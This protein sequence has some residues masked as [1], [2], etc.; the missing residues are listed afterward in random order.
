MLQSMNAFLGKWMPLLTP[1]SV[2]VGVLLSS[3]LNNFSFL[4]PWVFAAMTFTGSLNSNFKSMKHTIFHPLSLL[5]TLAVLHVIT[6]VWAYAIGHLFFGNDPYTIT[7]LTLATVI[8]TGITSVIWVSMYKGNVPLTLA[9]ILADTLLSPFLVPLSMSIFVGEAVQLDVWGMMRGL[10][11]MIVI[12]SIAGMAINQFYSKEKALH[13]NKTLAPFSKLGLAAVV[14]IN[15]S[16]VAPYLRHIDL[17]FIYVGLTMFFVALS[18]YF[19]S[20][21]LGVLTKRQKDETIAM[22]YTGGMRNISA[23]AVMAVSFFPPQVA[24][25]VVIGMLFQQILAAL[26]GQAI[27]LMYQKPALMEV[28]KIS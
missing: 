20:W 2:V 8:P 21:L 1:V 13:W 6:P 24:V 17:K 26:Y 16:V 15:S 22:I 9:I 3:F 25:P 23:G 14:A 18:G 28:K 7:G 19:F 11:V 12:P 5:L 27:R 4:V 10:L